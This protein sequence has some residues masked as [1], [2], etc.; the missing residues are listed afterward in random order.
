MARKDKTRDGPS[1]DEV[2][3]EECPRKNDLPTVSRNDNNNN[4]VDDH[5]DDDDDD[6]DHDQVLCWNPFSMTTGYCD[7]HHSMP[8]IL[9]LS[10]LVFG[11]SIGFLHNSSRLYWSS[12][13]LSV[14]SSSSSSG[15]NHHAG[16]VINAILHDLVGFAIVSMTV[17]ILLYLL[18]EW[19]TTTFFSDTDEV[20]QPTNDVDSDVDDD[21]HDEF[22]WTAAPS[23]SL[24]SSPPV[25]I[26]ISC[27]LST[28]V[29]MG[30]CFSY[31][32]E[33]ALSQAPSHQ[34]INE[35][36]YHWTL[37]VI[38]LYVAFFPWMLLMAWLTYPTTKKTIPTKDDE[39]GYTLLLLE[40]EDNNNEEVK[41]ALKAGTHLPFVLV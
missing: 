36:W 30:S 39:D 1:Q 14:S 19:A 40:K 13:L 28:G 34:L 29:F 26:V 22:T 37:F 5:N 11:A 24:S 21:D 7:D 41:A 35:N 17:N 31:A 33:I 32:V 4:D 6:D 15:C 20:Q 2:E 8:L 23:S 12:F 10:L 3:E 25:T 27:I 38:L 9:V 18:L 16:H